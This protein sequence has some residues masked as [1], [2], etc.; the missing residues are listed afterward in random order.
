MLDKLYSTL[1]N[2]G[3]TS[4]SFEEFK[5]KFKD[6]AWRQKLHEKLAQHGATNS[7][8]ED[9]NNKFSE[10]QAIT[11]ATQVDVAVAEPPTADEIL[12]S[13][14]QPIQQPTQVETNQQES[15][16]KP[17]PPL[18]EQG[19][20]GH[21]QIQK[22]AELVISKEQKKKNALA[23]KLY[24][25]YIID[26][27]KNRGIDITDP[28][29]IDNAL[30][31]DASTSIAKEAFK[32][33][34]RLFGLIQ[35]EIESLSFSK[36]VAHGG[37]LM[38]SGIGGS[39]K[40]REDF[41]EKTLVELKQKASKQQHYQSEMEKQDLQ[42]RDLWDEKRKDNYDAFY[43]QHIINLAD[44]NLAGSIKELQS[45]WDQIQ[46]AEQNNDLESIRKLKTQYKAALEK[47]K[48][49]EID[50]MKRKNDPHYKALYD[51]NTFERID[52]EFA[53]ED[54]ENILDLTSVY[55]NK[56]KE[57]EEKKQKGEYESF[58]N[59]FDIFNLRYQDHHDKLRST[60]NVTAPKTS[61]YAQSLESFGYTPENGVYK[62][63]QY[64]DIIRLRNFQ[65]KTN[66]YL[67]NPWKKGEIGSKDI[68]IQD[69]SSTFGE[70]LEA[71]QDMIRGLEGEAMA[72]K[73]LYLLNRDP[74]SI[75]RSG[76]F[77]ESLIEES[78][79]VFGADEGFIK[80]V[81]PL[82]HHD[83]LEN[84][85]TAMNRTLRDV[86]DEEGNVIGETQFQFTKNQLKNF[87]LTLW[88]KTGQ[89]VGGVVPMVVEFGVLNAVTGGAMNVS[90]LGRAVSL[91]RSG[92]YFRNGKALNNKYF[93]RGVP[94]SN[95]KKGE[96]KAY[97]SG[98]FAK[99]ISKMGGGN[100]DKAKALAITAAIEDGKMQFIGM[101]EGVG[102][103]F[104]IAGTGFNKL[105]QRYGLKF[106]G[107]LGLL[108]NAP[109]KL[110]KS[111][112]SLMVASEVADPIAAAYDD[113]TG[114]K[115]F[116]NFVEEHYGD[117]L[118]GNL[119]RMYLNFIA[120]TAF[121]STNLGKTDL[122]NT[123]GR[124][125]IM[126][127]RLLE[128]NA[129][130]F[131]KGVG[132]TPGRG[133]SLTKKQKSELDSNN[134][135]IN[136]LMRA[137]DV[138]YNTAKYFDINL[139]VRDLNTRFENI[140]KKRS[141][142]GKALINV[143]IQKN[144]RGM[145]KGKV[146]EF[147]FET[148]DGK[149]NYNKPFIRMNASK[150]NPGTLPHEVFH[151]LTQEEFKSDPAVFGKLKNVIEATVG[152]A[153]PN[154]KNIIKEKYGDQAKESKPIEYFA[155]LVDIL[156]KPEFRD[157]LLRT[158]TYGLIG[159]DLLRFFENRLVGTRLEGFLPEVRDANDI[160]S[161]LKRLGDQTL[162]GDATAQIKRLANVKIDGR[163]ITRTQDE[164]KKQGYKIPELFKF[165]SKELEISK[166]Y[167]EATK[168][169]AS[170]Y[171]KYA[172][173]GL[174]KGEKQRMSEFL[175]L[176]FE[177]TVQNKIKNILPNS[178]RIEVEN[179]ASRFVTSTKWATDKRGLADLINEYSGE[180]GYGIEK[181]IGKFYQ[182]RLLE[183]TKDQV[184]T[185]SIDIVPESGRPLSETLADVSTSKEIKIIQ[186]PKIQKVKKEKVKKDKDKVLTISGEGVINTT[187]DITN[188]ILEGIPKI[189]ISKKRPLSYKS[190]Q[191]LS[192]IETNKMFGIKDQ[193]PGNL[194]KPNT[195]NAQKFIQKHAEEIISILPEGA[196]GVKGISEKL[197]GT[198]TGVQDVLLHEF[199]TQ[200]KGRNATAAGLDVYSKNANIE[201]SQL[202][203]LIGFNKETKEFGYDRN[204]SSRVK[205]LVTQVGKATTNQILRNNIDLIPEKELQKV[206][207]VNNLIND[208]AS[209]KSKS[210]AAKDIIELLTKTY[211]KHKLNEYKI[212]KWLS[213]YH[214]DRRLLR[215]KYDENGLIES[216][217]EDK[218]I[219]LGKPF[220]DSGIGYVEA[221]GDAKILTTLGL[222]GGT[223]KTSVAKVRENKNGE[224]EELHSG[225]VNE[226]VS[227][228]K[229]PLGNKARATTK[230]ISVF[231]IARK[232]VGSEKAR[233]GMKKADPPSDFIA[234]IVKN[235]NADKLKGKNFKMS[236]IYS[237]KTVK[238][239]NKF[240]KDGGFEALTGPYTGTTYR[241][242]I[243]ASGKKGL[244][245]QKKYFEKYY[246]SKQGKFESNFLD[247][248]HTMQKE[249]LH[250]TSKALKGGLSFDTKANHILYFQK[251][252]STFTTTLNRISAPIKYV[253]F[254]GR[255]WTSGKKFEHLL[256]SNQENI[257]STIKILDNT[258]TLNRSKT[259][260]FVG[261]WGPHFKW[262]KLD[263]AQSKISIAGIFR[264]AD[265]YNMKTAKHV[266]L[267]D[268]M[269]KTLYDEMTEIV[270]KKEIK[271]IEKDLGIKNKNLTKQAKEKGIYLGSKDITNSELIRRLETRARALANAR[272]PKAP[273][274]GASILDFDDTVAKTKSMITYEIPKH[275]RSG[276]HLYG[277]FMGK[278]PAKGKLT[279]AEFAEQHAELEKRG[280]IFNFSEFSKIIGGKK[281]PLF[282]KLVKINE[283][284]GT[285]NTFIL[286]ARPPEAAPA[287]QRFL[288]GLGV[289]IKLENIIGLEDGRPG[290]KVNFIVEK[291]ANGYNDFYFVD[292]VTQNVRAVKNIVNILGVN[293]KI[294]QA[295][296]L[297]SKDLNKEFHKILKETKG[298]E[299]WKKYSKGTAKTRGADIGKWQ[300][301]LP[302]SAQ[303]FL[304][305]MYP[306]FGKGK[307]GDGHMKW[308]DKTLGRPYAQ[309][310]Y[311]LNKSKQRVQDD[312]EA[313]KKQYPNIKKIVNK[314]SGYHKFTNDAAMRVYLWNKNK[315]DIPELSK[316]DVK[317]LVKLVKS[318]PELQSY[319]DQ[320]SKLTQLKDGYVKPSES[321]L[322]KSI[323]HDLLDVSNKVGRKQFFAEWI[324]N[325]N[326]IFTEAT[327][328]KLEATFGS[329][330]RSALEDMLY[331]MEHGHNVQ[332]KST[333]A[334]KRYSKWI[335]NATGTVMF[336]NRRSA[337]TQSI[338]MLNFMN[339]KD[340]G[341][342]DMGRAFAN[343]PQFW[344]DFVMIWN[345]PMLKQRRK[346]LTMDVNY[347][348]IVSTM[349]GKKDK[350]SAGVS[351]MLHKGFIFTKIVDNWAIAFGGATMYRNRIN[352]YLKQGVKKDKV[353]KEA[354]LDFQ[355][356]SE[357]TQQSS[358][359]DLVSQEQASPWGRFLLTFQNV[360]MQNNRNG[361][362]AVL[363]FVNRRGDMKTNLS[364]IVY[365]FGVQNMIF[366]GMQ[367]A[368]FAA[369]WDDDATDE[370]R[371]KKHLK[372]GNGLL[373]VYLRGGGMY[374]VG[375]ATIKNTILKYMEESKKG[376]KGSEAK[377]LVEALNLSPPV[378]SK[379]RKIHTAMV[380]RKYNKDSIVKPLVLA[381]E[382]ATN[383]P[384][385]EFFEMVDSGVALTDAQLQAWQKVAIALGYPEWQVD[386]KP[387]PP[388]KK[389]KV[390]KKKYNPLLL[391]N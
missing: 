281:G 269:K 176:D 111:G 252:N 316:R 292:D 170:D 182:K 94:K 331:R 81:M 328:N 162:R 127:N 390:K 370:D 285:E 318:N 307:Q 98:R 68:I 204:V 49:A 230:L 319:A 385:H 58:E 264:F 193:K 160:L 297:A 137:R 15:I 93:T 114:N 178:N 327:L 91:L 368:L 244:V 116:K 377:V 294:R 355:E 42:N 298:I 2:N 165:S 190:L 348:E 236:D 167:V 245:N 218:I 126:I 220:K 144:S 76:V 213:M 374:G 86:K 306:T 362:R 145:A 274:K 181:W 147:G 100:L 371:T 248:F 36:S 80:D 272:D 291:A 219:D 140:N 309:G 340:N 20:T 378:G 115:S 259:K 37:D 242:F 32:G 372:M 214:S 151:L 132:I 59:E 5:E 277:V 241:A 121:G 364:K 290:A 360:T 363:D 101:D 142:Q 61:M 134:E 191:D 13:E 118:S 133:K 278:I 237:E 44:V 206:L 65:N 389:K 361:K 117:T 124:N 222:K 8:Y 273:L 350:V 10:K 28:E 330:Y 300:W 119:E 169:L 55:K 47:N 347:E 180:L 63:V 31:D 308:F 105:S 258:Y 238:A 53:T 87:E 164:M 388:P 246:D 163:T 70:N 203:K 261:I 260:N 96:L 257:N 148:V 322:A 64:K 233:V 356:V 249:W 6:E 223:W 51:L 311:E 92:K 57:L 129:E 345:S 113:I 210:L 66:G 200:D 268:N 202:L 107:N 153:I 317:E 341:P 110:G 276:A 18:M 25:Q 334:E 16:F 166:N 43:K 283:K 326:A 280:A 177:K 314:D 74:A 313:L 265:E 226:F 56:K 7:N 254:D 375:I 95:L 120:G 79:R 154:Y 255:V 196:V 39:L 234:E 386:Y 295:K 171:K 384:F 34:S 382:G 179:I 250:S 174:P 367:Q 14:L 357:P 186:K 282:E 149:P 321:W 232:T 271:Q 352:T 175:A 54:D 128:R 215:E 239:W 315:M 333:D 263:G 38:S 123:I 304:D 302:P 60:F 192:P 99:G 29:A 275:V 195:Q 104:A 380:D 224:L 108:L 332:R 72:W 329:R 253:Y 267:A 288:K 208:I 366:L 344:K 168:K 209:G 296:T 199:Y 156:Q 33:K 50:Y 207:T 158:N 305:L 62:D 337:L 266:Y 240:I 9:F 1:L 228:L 78:A 69:Q 339:W 187:K 303:G 22:P 77:L 299:E 83:K 301:W 205:A 71:E 343:Q 136:E 387:T 90:G 73:D 75:K 189:K 82:T 21:V 262:N 227:T 103:G 139:R 161:L 155:N 349:E 216:W 159:Q 293:G 383:I 287:I 324:N 376:W 97:L 346:G 323:Q 185:K 194:T 143:K 67:D 184:F 369:Y 235:L 172:V 289:D 84:I 183:F 35:D 3:V 4:M 351:Y 135:F 157:M 335:A 381:A 251:L 12:V 89:T 342:I 102:A 106:S 198:S 221:M 365:Y 197:K 88:Q 131:E 11:P 17:E 150:V 353:E 312:Y 217:V 152:K 19:T 173:E 41:V 212:M 40:V 112:L 201:P 146:A 46:T 45:L 30:K 359:P 85:Q 225:P 256:S 24:K 26:V 354:F 109:L 23:N 286:T 358:R 270:T 122:Y 52:Q 130:I 284:Y 373:D 125:G 27:L 279:P 310:F 138:A 188:Q 231:N 243:N 338:S 141:E 336:L 391:I 211:P 229:L 379:V 48:D 320:I 325:K 247:L